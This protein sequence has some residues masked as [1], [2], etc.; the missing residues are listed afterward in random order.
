MSSPTVLFVS[1]APNQNIPLRAEG[2]LRIQKC[3][4]AGPCYPIATSPGPDAPGSTEAR[5]PSGRRPGEL[6]RQR[7]CRL[8]AICQ[9]SPTVQAVLRASEQGVSGLESLNTCRIERNR[10]GLGGFLK[11]GSSLGRNTEQTEYSFRWRKRRHDTRVYHAKNA[12][13][14]ARNP[15]LPHLPE[16]TPVP[17]PAPHLLRCLPAQPANEPTR[18]LSGSQSLV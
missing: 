4:L 9:D 3:A 17:S 1:R 7:A 6:K 5:T 13:A 14:T 8:E 2:V 16:A 15:G 10:K 12:V 11:M 18:D